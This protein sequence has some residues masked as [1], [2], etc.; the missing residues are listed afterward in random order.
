MMEGLPSS[1]CRFT[2]IDNL[3]KTLVFKLEAYVLSNLGM[4]SRVDSIGEYEIDLQDIY[5]VYK[6]HRVITL[7]CFRPTV[8]GAEPSSSR[9]RSLSEGENQITLCS[10]DK[11]SKI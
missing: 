9:K 7:W 3:K 2:L 8:G 1:T 10:E 11:T 5:S 4:A 6:K